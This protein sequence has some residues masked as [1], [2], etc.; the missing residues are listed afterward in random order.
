MRMRR[1]F[2]R[3]SVCYYPSHFH[4][5][6]LSES[7][8]GFLSPS[9]CAA[10]RYHSF[11][12]GFCPASGGWAGVLLIISDILPQSPSLYA[13]HGTGLCFTSLKTRNAT[14]ISQARN[15]RGMRQDMSI[16]LRYFVLYW[17]CFPVPRCP[18]AFP[19]ASFSS[20]SLNMHGFGLI[21]KTYPS[22]QQIPLFGAFTSSAW[23]FWYDYSSKFNQCTRTAGDFQY[24]F[25]YVFSNQRPHLFITISRE[26]ANKEETSYAWE[27][28]N[29]LVYRN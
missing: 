8:F 23:T 16:F 4:F 29:I 10:K 5:F 20:V 25:Q 26:I 17:I 2:S 27:Y 7:S 3:S 19:F 15:V 24:I 18:P 9:G 12:P 22:P 1:L 11:H 14:L 28:K 13:H 6:A 21:S